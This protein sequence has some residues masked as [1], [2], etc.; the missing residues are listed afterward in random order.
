MARLAR[1]GVISCQV[2]G[3]PWPAVWRGPFLVAAQRR[4]RR[5]RR[6]GQRSMLRKPCGPAVERWG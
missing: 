2:I 3:R 1:A 6:S 4:R 5:K